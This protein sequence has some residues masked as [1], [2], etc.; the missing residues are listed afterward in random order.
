MSPTRILRPTSGFTSGSTYGGRT[1]LSPG[2]R[3][4]W[5]ITRPWATTA[6]TAG[7]SGIA[8]YSPTY[9]AGCSSEPA[10]RA[11]TSSSRTWSGSR[12]EPSSMR[13]SP[14]TRTATPW[15]TAGSARRCA[16]SAASACCSPQAG[17]PARAAAAASSRPAGS[18]TSSRAPLTGRRPSPRREQHPASRPALTTGTAG[19][20]ASRTCRSSM[21][22][23]SMAR[24]C[25]CTFPARRSWPSCRRGRSRSARRRCARQPMRSARSPRR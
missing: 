23:A 12:W 21:P 6:H 15:P 7:R 16:T 17:R 5:S 13:R 1:D 20:Y 3:T 25:S 11:C 4:H 2:R 14:S 24:T 10:E 19:G 8:R 18:A 9:S 22:P